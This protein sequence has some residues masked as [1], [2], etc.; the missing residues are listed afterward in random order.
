MRLSNCFFITRREFPNDEDTLSAK[1]LIK[2]GIIYKNDKGI[3]SYLPFGFK[4]VENI[5]KI[6]RDEFYK[7]NANE[8]IMP[9]LVPSRVF[10]DTGRKELFNLE[11]YNLI[12]RN[13]REYSLCPTSEELFAMLSKNKIMSYKDLHF[14]LFQIGNKFRDEESL[15]CGIS[16]KKEFIMADAYS[17]D[18]NDG[19]AD[20]SYDKMYLAFKNIFT[21]I[22]LSTMVV[23][24][25]AAYMKGLSS[26][27]FQVLS[28]YGDNSVVKCTNCT[29]TS[30]IEDADCKNKYKLYSDKLDRKE[31]INTHGITDILELSKKLG[32]PVSSFIKSFIFKINGEYK[33][34]LLRGNSNININKLKRLFNT[35]DII[36][37]SSYEL[38]KIGTVDEFYGPIDCT[39]EIIA[40]N[41]IK[42]LINAVVG[43]NKKNK[44]WI[45]ICPN[46]DFKVDRFADVKLFDEN[47]VCPKCKAK[48]NIL[49]G[50]EV[51]HIFKLGDNYSEIYDLK[52]TDEKNEINYVHM[53]SY[54]I[55]IDRCINSIAECYHDENGILWPMAVAPFKVGI[56]IANVND[57]DTF[58][59]AKTLYNKLNSMGID[60]LLDDRKESIG[61]K[62]ND[63]DLLGLPIRITVGQSLED[64]EVEFKLRNSIVTEYVSC[65]EV[66]NKIKETIEENS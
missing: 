60:C 20:I 36:V 31:L 45:N 49:K 9:S 59:Y 13:N 11:M 12:D 46:K 55:G 3:Y 56:I 65:D 28:E 54:G 58:K 24:S 17:F 29:F 52:Y 22:G 48:C 8:V 10:D 34:I 16:R 35:N 44:H 37:P 19:G 39:M 50:I 42:S 4:V 26:E 64:K 47:S 66:I 7:I 63:M 38:E 41:E 15:K 1:Y 61:V 21:K 62:F 32:I 30:N 5:K 43:S 23:R 18:A 53:G 51:G 27:E 57:H 33:M 2:S 25:D 6:I 40:D 14:T